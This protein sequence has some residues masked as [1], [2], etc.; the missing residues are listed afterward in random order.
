MAMVIRQSLPLQSRL[1]LFS[2]EEELG[3]QVAHHYALPQGHFNGG[4]GVPRTV[5]CGPAQTDLERK[6]TGSHLPDPMC[7]VTLPSGSCARCLYAW[8][9]FSLQTVWRSFSRSDRAMMTPCSKK[10]VLKKGRWVSTSEDHFR[11]F[12][13][14]I[15]LCVM[16]V[17][18]ACMCIYHMCPRNVS[19]KP[20]TGATIW[21]LRI[22]QEQQ[23][24]SKS[25]KYS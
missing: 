12:F 4:G 16:V 9:R 23:V 20:G 1:V 7:D 24:L 17:L 3:E 25:N 6:T 10:P 18:P 11:V 21:V 5:I 22:K 15:Y 13:L 8:C 19:K 14:S 2:T